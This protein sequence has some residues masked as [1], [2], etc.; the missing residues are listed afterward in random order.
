MKSLSMIKTAGLAL[1]AGLTSLAVSASVAL[2]Q[3]PAAPVPNKG[4]TAWMIVATLL[5]LMM[6]IPGL[7][8]FYGGLVRSKNMLS[9]LSQVFMIVSLVSILWVTYG[10]SLSFTSGGSLNDIFGALEQPLSEEEIAWVCACCARGLQY[11]HAQR[12]IHRDIKVCACVVV[13]LVTMD[14]MQCLLD[15]LT[16]ISPAARQHP[17]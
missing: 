15:V 12:K 4:D 3:T 1:G 13:A 6:S 8:L 9:V 2:A 17:D 11:M 5:V 10:Y 14:T 16:V 7:A